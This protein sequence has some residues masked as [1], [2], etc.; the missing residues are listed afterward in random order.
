MI[1]QVVVPVVARKKGMDEFYTSADGRQQKRPPSMI[2]EPVRDL[3]Q[4]YTVKET[5][6]DMFP[7]VTSSLI[8]KLHLRRQVL[9]ATTTQS[10]ART[11]RTTRFR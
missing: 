7:W 8:K 9:L 3:M 5:D 1:I 2:P 4:V 10:T 6:V 11:R